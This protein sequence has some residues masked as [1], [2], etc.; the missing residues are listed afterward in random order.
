M[1]P[2]TAAPTERS[3]VDGDTV[4]VYGHASCPMVPPV[5]GMLDRSG[6]L[7]NYVNIR[8]HPEAAAHVRQIN[9]GDESVPTLV[10]PDGV[11]LTEPSAGQLRAELRRRGYTVGIGAMLLGNMWLWLTPL[12]A[13][14]FVLLGQLI[15]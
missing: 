2:E 4:V 8:Q 7:Y 14:F 12:I 3:S 13:L 6:V 10:F 15:G 11:T 1:D 9:S 5:R